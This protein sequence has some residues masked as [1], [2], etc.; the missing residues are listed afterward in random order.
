[1]SNDLWQG[2]TM[3]I[4]TR[5]SGPPLGL[6]VTRSA[7]T[8]E[9]AFDQALARVG[10]STPVW[11]TLLAVKTGAGRSQRELA[12]VIGI[13]GAT[14]TH[15]LA[16]MERTGL[17]TRQRRADN[18][19]VQLVELT[20]TGLD[21]FVACARTAQDFDRQLR[22]GIDPSRLADFAEVLDRLRRNVAPDSE[23]PGGP[24]SPS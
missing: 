20:D 16:A 23:P 19:R 22:E 6:L 13:Q 17:L 2:R 7:R 18:R 9:R 3:M 24:L 15:H 4:M 1:M 11:L 21:L 12:R 5:P 8:L 14:L 10:A